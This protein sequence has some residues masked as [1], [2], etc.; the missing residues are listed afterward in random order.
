[1]VMTLVFFINFVPDYTWEWHALFMCS[2]YGIEETTSVKETSIELVSI[3]EKQLRCEFF[4]I[5][6]IIVREMTKS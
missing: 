1:M 3:K 2:I 4:Y 5:V 6:F